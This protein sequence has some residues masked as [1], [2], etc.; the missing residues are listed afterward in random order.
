MAVSENNDILNEELEDGAMG[1][2]IPDADELIE[3][4]KNKNY[5]TLR[6]VTADVPPSDIAE[7]LNGFPERLSNL[8]FRLLPKDIAAEVFALLDPEKCEELIEIFTDKELSNLLAELYID[9]TVD[10]IE[11]MPAAV[12]KR[13]LKNS[14][15][16]DRESI[17]QLLR[18][19]E[20]TAGTIMTTE[21]VSLRPTM[22]VAEALSHIR[23]VAIDKET[24][25][26]S[27]VTDD[28]KKLMGIVTAK[29]LLLASP[30][31]KISDVMEDRIIFATTEEDKESVALKFNKYGFIS[32]P[33][34]DAE[35]RLVGIVTVDDAIDVLKEEVEEDISKMAA[36]LPDDT[37]Y[38]RQSPFNL[39]KA[40]IPWLLFLMV[41]ATFSAAILSFFEGTLLPVLTIFLPMLMGTGGNSGSQSSVTAIRAIGSGEMTIRDVPRIFL[42]ELLVGLM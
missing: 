30:E 13:I 14:S 32:L 4:I 37:P 29:R 5:Q 38:V 10:I 27:F 36:I 6:K 22:T 31:E 23:E 28:K 1:Y 40:R 35:R 12:V 26:T 9:D 15:A 41:S 19:K 33:V 7:I 42:K 21:Y 11:E 2:V 39:F 34:V 20:D 25:Y 24:I 17:N 16:E 3:L 18:Y 8:F